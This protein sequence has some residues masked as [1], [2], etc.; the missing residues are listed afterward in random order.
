MSFATTPRKDNASVT[1]I[2]QTP[3]FTIVPVFRLKAAV[4]L[5]LNMNS[6]L[7]GGL[8]VSVSMYIYNSLCGLVQCKALLYT[9]L[10]IPNMNLVIGYELDNHY[11][12]PYIS[13]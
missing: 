9:V 1:I 2:Q 4:T 6:T 12:E 11:D 13:R 5:L 8:R 3:I 10:T 7:I